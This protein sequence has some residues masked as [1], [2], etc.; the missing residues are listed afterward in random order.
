VGKKIKK[1]IAGLIDQTLLNP[2]SSSQDHF[3][4]C[5]DAKKYGFRT[6]CVY[7]HFIDQCVQDLEGTSTEVCT[8]IDFPEG[9]GEIE[10]NLDDVE[11]VITEGAMEIDMVMDINSFRLKKYDK[12]LTGIYSIVEAAAGRI[13]KVII[14][15]CHWNND[16]IKIACEIV[17]E[18]K[19]QFVKTSTG[20][21]TY[22]AK[23]SQVKII[24]Q[25]VGDLFG[26]KA[27][28]GVNT[29]NDTIKMIEAGAN[30]IGTSS[31]VKIIQGINDS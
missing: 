22:G 2:D 24:R 16:E 25:A 14:E 4:L 5:K 29:F 9:L 21:S 10:R 6:V 17:K 26:V 7:P 13:V 27:S 19:A 28:G 31:G 20:F 30:R 3:I 23:Y 8:V 1:K 15:S 11:R 18:A 12:V